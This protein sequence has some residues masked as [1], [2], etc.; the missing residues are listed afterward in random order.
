MIFVIFM[1][2]QIAVSRLYD[3]P[4]MAYTKAPGAPK[5]AFGKYMQILAPLPADGG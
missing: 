2:D 3:L 5:E 1:I 4:K